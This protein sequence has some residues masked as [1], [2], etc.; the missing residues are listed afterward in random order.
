MT[1]NEE[2]DSTMPEQHELLD[3]GAR[4]VVH[5]ASGI[6]GA[7]GAV[8]MTASVGGRRLTLDPVLPRAVLEVQPVRPESTIPCGFRT[9]YA[10]GELGGRYFEVS[11]G[12]GN[13]YII[14]RID[15]GP[16]DELGE[17]PAIDE[18]IDLSSV[19]TEWVKTAVEGLGPR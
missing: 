12:V 2:K 15:S 14:L 10:T 16:T 9:A 8:A 11:I 17:Q 19:I 6:V 13:P 1:M 7:S 18:F 5:Q 3:R 4:A